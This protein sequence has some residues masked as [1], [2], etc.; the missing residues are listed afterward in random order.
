MRGLRLH[1]GAAP[2]AGGNI[3][4]LHRPA[5]RLSQLAWDPLAAPQ[6]T[7]ALLPPA[8]DL[9]PGRLA[10]NH[11]PGQLPPDVPAGYPDGA[12]GHRGQEQAGEGGLPPHER[13]RKGHPS[14]YSLPEDIPL[15]GRVSDSKNGSISESDSAPETVSHIKTKT[16]TVPLCPPAGETGFGE[17]LQG[18]FEG[19]LAYKAEKRQGYQPTG[20]QCLVT[21]VRKHAGRYGEA[22]VA[23]LIRECMASNWQGIAF[24]RLK[25]GAPPEEEH[26]WRQ[27]P[28]TGEWR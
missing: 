3:Y 14:I 11:P 21:E 24:D 12:G 26:V 27:D 18:A 7:A 8:G 2:A 22:A 19:W 20:L 28:E 10:G 9:Q 25:R 4:D 6:L 5:E 17:E 23:A 1:L 16:K 13:G 15:E